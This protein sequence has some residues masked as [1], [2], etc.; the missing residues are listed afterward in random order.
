M[1]DNPLPEWDERPYYGKSFP[2][3]SNGNS[4]ILNHLRSSLDRN[5]ASYRTENSCGNIL[6]FGIAIIIAIKLATELHPAILIIVPVFAF[7]AIYSIRNP[8][9]DEKDRSKIRENAIRNLL[10]RGLLAEM[11]NAE[12]A[13]QVLPD[14][15]RID[16][17]ELRILTLPEFH[18]THFKS[19]LDRIDFLV[20]NYEYICHSRKWAYQQSNWK[21]DPLPGT[22][23]F[24]KGRHKLH[25]G[26]G[27]S[28][29]RQIVI[30][31]LID[32]LEGRVDGTGD[33]GGVEK[34][35]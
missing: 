25:I 15:S 32:I 9:F 28:V 23:H 4:A 31:A 11:L 8:G 27:N 18:D 35:Q 3:G 24:S 12:K 16:D 19:A 1:T 17:P 26:G 6:A 5:K 30:Q 21:Y 33:N 13:S 10:G 14:R 34:M 22:S 2:A 20:L 7:A 29:A